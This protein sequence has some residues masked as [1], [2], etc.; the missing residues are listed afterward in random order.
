MSN[1][2]AECILF[3]IIVSVIINI[4]VMKTS[5]LIELMRRRNDDRNGSIADAS[6]HRVPNRVPAH[7]SPRSLPT[8]RASGGSSQNIVRSST[9][10]IR[11]VPPPI[12]TRRMDMSRRDRDSY[13]RCPICRSS[14][15]PGK[16]QKI[17]WDSN[18]NRWRCV[19]GHS[20]NS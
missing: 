11:T 7:G 20:F 3:G 10:Q 9:G 15:R 14:N 17:F 5:N 13:P 16:A 2:M 18:N 4:V 6:Q 19:E 1:G 12:P 8:Q